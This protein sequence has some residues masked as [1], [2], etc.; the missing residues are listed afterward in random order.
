MPTK[1]ICG[2]AIRRNPLLIVPKFQICSS[3]DGLQYV[4]LE[5]SLL[6]F[7]FFCFE[8]HCTDADVH[9]DA[10]TIIPTTHVQNPTPM[11]TPEGWTGLCSTYCS[12]FRIT[13]YRC[14]CSHRHT[15]SHPYE[16]THKILPLMS[17]S[18]GRRGL[19][20][21]C[22]FFSNHTIQT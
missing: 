4:G 3:K 2:M 17:T 15:H 6:N 12:F 9:T 5:R 18:E 19:Y 21:T 1:S 13:R 8:S 7:L 14:M 10:L 22:S 20:L 11:S 16:H